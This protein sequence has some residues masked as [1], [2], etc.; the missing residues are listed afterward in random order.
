MR[1]GILGA[2]RIAASA[3]IPALRANR[4]DIVAVACRDA[5]RGAAFA[6][7]HHI[8]E[9]VDY[10][11]LIA[12]DDIDVIYNALPNHAHLPWTLTALQHGKH[13]LCEKPLALSAGEVEQMRDASRA[14]G[15]LV[16]EAFMY[17]FH[18]QFD[19]LCEL[20]ASGAL[21]PLKWMRGS[22]T[23]ALRDMTD[24]RWD[25]ALG[26]GALYDL[27]CYPLSLMRSLAGVEPVVLSVASRLTEPGL[28]GGSVDH[29]AHAVL[30]FDTAAGP[31]LGHFDAAFSLPWHCQF[32]LLCEHGLL[33]LPI[34][35]ATKGV[36]TV[37]QV[38]EQTERFA[39]C[40]PY[41]T[42]VGH[43]EAA[44]RGEC[45]LRF[46]LDESLGQARA[47]DALLAGAHATDALNT[48]HERPP[49]AII[50]P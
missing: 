16:L 20:V 33:R 9:A 48:S 25:P 4:S 41:A 40:D 8:P 12:R 14:S 26:G 34:P 15:R 36:E 32:E 29:A 17:R 24:C 6:A 11:A 30:R 13:V 28:Y 37:L 43:F 19:R 49:S 38:G 44:V 1:W 31:V 5:A 47:M 21:G 39:I 7:T 35:F 46:G 3:L 50:A 45:A 2:A 10:D 22:F 23:Y 18:P 27:G 42:M